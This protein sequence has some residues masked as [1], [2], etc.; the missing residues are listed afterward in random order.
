MAIFFS[1][2]G[3]IG[4][5]CL[6]QANQLTEALIATFVV[7]NGYKSTFGLKLGIGIFIC[8]IVSIVVLGGIERISKYQPNLS[9]LLVALYFILVGYIM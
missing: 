1:I 5:L 7:P 3:L 4:T 8:F 6:M 2:F 9:Q